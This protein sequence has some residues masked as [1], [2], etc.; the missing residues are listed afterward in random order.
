[1]LEVIFTADKYLKNENEDIVLNAVRVIM[2]SAIHLTGKVQC[3]QPKDD[4]IVRNLIDLLN[5]E[6]DDIVTNVR[7][8][9]V[10]IADL[11]KGFKIIV[12]YLSKFIDHLDS[13]R[14]PKNIF[15]N[16]K[17]FCRLFPLFFLLTPQRSSARPQ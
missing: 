17:F 14:N 8:T 7:H 11:P 5:S 16:Y 9:L 1:M 4:I 2:F 3:T 13:V 15:S 10:N 12:R 6:N